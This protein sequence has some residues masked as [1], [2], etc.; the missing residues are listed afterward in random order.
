MQGDKQPSPYLFATSALR[1]S[2]T[3]ER[4]TVRALQAARELM[5]GEPDCARLARIWRTSLGQSEVVTGE[6]AAVV[7]PWR[8]QSRRLLLH[9][10]VAFEMLLSPSEEKGPIRKH[11]TGGLG[12]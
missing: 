7:L 10:R 3:W 12:T 4:K 8:R 2:F 11:F 6:R 9:C 5:R 1:M